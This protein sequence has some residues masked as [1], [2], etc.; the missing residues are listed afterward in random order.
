MSSC[1][2]GGLCGSKAVGRGRC[3]TWR[4]AADRPRI[5][6][7]W[8]TSSAPTTPSM[9]PTRIGTEPTTE[10]GEEE[11]R[12]NP[13]KG[14]ERCFHLKRRHRRQQQRQQRQQQDEEG[15]KP[16]VQEQVLSLLLLLLLLILLVVVVVLGGG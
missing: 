12:L 2:R 1:W 14:F 13:K 7:T 6:G 10:A 4:R 3:I 9:P 11:G 8:V 15:Q 5:L 16:Q